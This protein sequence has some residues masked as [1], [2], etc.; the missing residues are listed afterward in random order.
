ML[1]E[2]TNH[3]D[4]DS[5]QALVDAIN[6]YRGA[7]VLVTHDLHL[8][9]LCAE[10]LW[11]ARGGTCRPFDGDIREYRSA[12]LDAR[13]AERRIHRHNRQADGGDR[14][15]KSA[16][17]ENAQ[18]RAMRARHRKAVAAAERRVEQLCKERA[19]IERKLA[20]PSLYSGPAAEI[21]KLNRHLS[22]IERNIVLAESEWLA[23]EEAANPGRSRDDAEQ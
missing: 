17:R 10:R 20:D 22:E 19:S 14:S 18:F 5:R 1:D 4:M 21:A 11:L 16:R 7:V 3:L 15:R 13:R 8:V 9:E 23:A 12:V 2:P 6:A